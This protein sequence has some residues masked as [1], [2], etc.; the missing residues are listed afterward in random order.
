MFGSTY[1]AVFLIGLL[2]GLE[3]GHG[4]PVAVIYA[5]RMRRPM[6]R[7]LTAS[8]I[9]A[10]FHLISS[11]AVVAVYVLLRSYW[12][13]SIPYVNYIAGGVLLILAVKS[14]LEKPE[15]TEYQHGHTHDEL[16]I[17]EHEHE[18][19]HPGGVKHTH[20]HSHRRKVLLTLKGISIFAFLLGFAHEEEFAL[21]SLAVGGV[22]PWLM[23]LAYALAV[24]LGIIGITLAGIRVY[25]SLQ[26]RFHRY[27]R[28]LPK[29]TA[30]ILALLALSFLLGLR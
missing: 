30:V 3:P 5:T 21:L 17:L 10:F 2:H 23:M 22:N 24:T 27:E 8:A 19:E 28:F 16:E 12:S 14:W 9:L 7:G 29:I 1:L 6:L 18:H 20:K 15:D 25:R 4:W 26:A 11:F 13:F